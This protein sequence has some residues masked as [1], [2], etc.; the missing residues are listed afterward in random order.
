MMDYILLGIMGDQRVESSLSPRLQRAALASCGLKGDYVRLAVEPCNFI[1]AQAGLWGL[2]YSG[3]NVT[4]PYKQLV[5]PYLQGISQPAAKI[6]AVNTLV[7][8]EQ[9]FIGHNTDISGCL[10]TI[11][12][13]SRQHT[14]A[15]LGSGGAARAMLAALQQ[16]GHKHVCLLGRNRQ[17]TEQ[18]A[19]SFAVRPVSPMPGSFTAD[20]F[21]NATTVSAR[22]EGEDLYALAHGLLP[23]RGVIDLNYGR[24]D[25]FWQALAQRHGVV[26]MDGLTMLAWQAKHAF[27]LWTGKN[28]AIEVFEEAL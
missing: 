24:T 21:I 20:W 13:I 27:A 25:N 17:K 5:M 12:P 10:E 26:F 3:V 2:G 1:E 22:A 23:L 11:K 14:V 15:L 28:V 16:Q 18:L 8:A 9:G 4:V 19:A 7:R 6:G